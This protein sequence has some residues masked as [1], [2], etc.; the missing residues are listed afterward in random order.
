M[1]F[2]FQ[3]KFWVVH[4][5]FVRMVKFQFFTQFPVDDLAHQV[6]SSLI[7][8]LLL[9]MCL[10]VS[11]LSPHNLHLLFCFVLSILALYDWPLW[12]CFVL[13][14]DEILLLYYYY[15]WEFFT[16]A[17]S[18]G[19]SNSLSPQVSRTLLRIITD[20]NN[21]VVWMVST[22]LSIFLWLNRAHQLQLVS[23]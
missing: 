5:P 11:S 10:M 17:L 2:I 19:L 23:K 4:I 12:R 3:N 22:L 15:I 20:L 14:L 9:I 1:L 8:F 6:V 16:S 13:R 18:G 21:A 7:L